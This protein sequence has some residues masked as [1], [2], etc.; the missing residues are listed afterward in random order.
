[1]KQEL[2]LFVREINR[3]CAE[4]NNGLAAVAA[5]LAILTF[6]RGSDPVVRIRSNLVGVGKS[7][8]IQSSRAETIVVDPSSP[9]NVYVDLMRATKMM[10]RLRLVAAIV[11]IV[12]AMTSCVSHYCGPAYPDSTDPFCSIHWPSPPT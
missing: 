10:R 8:P 5:V 1:M 7:F 6:F 9:S 12:A 11:L 3:F 2:I 4:L